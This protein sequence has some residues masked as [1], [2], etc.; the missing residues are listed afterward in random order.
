M[1]EL[2]PILVAVLN[3]LLP[4]SGTWPRASETRVP[5]FIAGRAAEL[6]DFAKA[7]DTVCTLLPADFVSANLASRTTILRAAETHIPD[8]FAQLVTEA[9]RGYYTDARVLAQI[10][11]QTGY[12]AR[13]PQPHGREVRPTDWSVLAHRAIAPAPLPP[14]LETL[15]EKSHDG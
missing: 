11:N 5:T 2:D 15:A 8:A 9:Y 1:T 6:P 10:E 3:T 12:P 13:P 4:G 14:L 7:L